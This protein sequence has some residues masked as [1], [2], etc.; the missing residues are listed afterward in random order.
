[1]IAPPLPVTGP[2]LRAMS[3]SGTLPPVEAPAERTDRL[4]LPSLEA[5]HRET[6]PSPLSGAGWCRE[7]AV[8]RQLLDALQAL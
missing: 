5:P 8:L 3:W 6:P 7:P 4:Y 2:R 1:V